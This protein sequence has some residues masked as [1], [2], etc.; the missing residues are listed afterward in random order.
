MDFKKFILP[1]VILII[2]LLFIFI[3][4]P[5]AK[6]IN[7]PAEINLTY[8]ETFS[9]GQKTLLESNKNIILGSGPATFKYNYDLY[10]SKDINLTNLWS[11]RFSQGTSFLLT[12]IST[13]GLLGIIAFI[14]LI[15]GFFWQAY[16]QMYR[17][18]NMSYR[19]YWIC[20]VL[21]VYFLVCLLLYKVNF[22]L[23]LSNFLFLGMFITLDN[24]PKHEFIFTKQPQTAFFT[25]LICV[26][27]IA[28]IG[29]GYYKIGKIYAGSVNFG[30]AMRLISAESTDLNKGIILLDKA[31]RF[32]V[33]DVYLRNLSQAY[34]FKIKQIMQIQSLTKHEKE[35]IIGR[36]S[37]RIEI[38]VNDAIKLIPNDSKNWEQFGEFYENFIFLKNTEKVRE[39]AILGYEKAIMLAPKNPKLPFLLARTYRSIAGKI[40]PEHEKYNQF[41]VLSIS[42][43]KNS[44]ELKNNFTPVFNLMPEVKRMQK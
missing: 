26:F 24:E 29:V 23:I 22:T 5:T 9:I 7:L 37:L 14:L 13:T 39:M 40:G 28:A 21:G 32:D 8:D 33:K 36:L 30:K 34:L 2:S 3:K 41:L 10:H 35:D 42:E 27:L 38:S 11:A 12:L 4:I 17:T 18:N 25:M 31:I 20:F 1:L 43:L 16:K 15:A 19:T 44:L 6:M